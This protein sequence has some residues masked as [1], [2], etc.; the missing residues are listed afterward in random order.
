MYI[1]PNTVVYFCHNVPLDNTYEHTIYWHDNK[2]NGLAL[3]ED[4]FTLDNPS[5]PNP[6]LKF[7]LIAQ[8]FQDPNDNTIRVEKPWADLLD[9]N[10][11]CFRNDSFKN[12]DNEAKM[13]YAF[14]TKVTYINNNVTEIEYEIDVM[15]TW[16]YDYDLKEC[17]VER[18]HTLTDGWFEHTLAEDLD[19][20]DELVCTYHKVVDLNSRKT[21]N[22]QQISK[23][24][25]LLNRKKAGTQQPASGSFISGV[26]AGTDFI[27]G[28][29]AN[30]T[31]TIDGYLNQYQEDEIVAIYQYPNC[32]NDGVYYSDYVTIPKVG[33]E[34]GINEATSEY[35]A[36]EDYHGHNL[37]MACYPYSRL[38]L[39][40][41]AGQVAEFKYE[42]L[43]FNHE[44]YPNQALFFV[45]GVVL[46][47]PAII[48]YPDSYRGIYDRDNASYGGD[49]DSGMIMSN[50]PQCSWA[51]DT[52]K[53]WWAQNHNQFQTGLLTGA[54]TGAV[55][56]LTSAAGYG[57]PIPLATG[58]IS[59]GANIANQMALKMDMHY[60]PNMTHGTAQT[61]TL[62]TQ[63][64]RYRFDF[65]EMKVKPEVAMLIDQY[66]SKYGYKVNQVKVPNRK[67]R[68]F[69]T[70]T[71]TV[72]CTITETI[73][74]DIAKKICSIYDN[75]I[76][77]W[78]YGQTYKNVSHAPVVHLGEYS[79][80]QYTGSDWIDKWGFY[81]PPL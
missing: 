11:M 42:L 74:N 54:I 36:Y 4:Y 64:H 79:Y 24:C 51:G 22:G 17:F 20:G 50:F 15:Q 37:K 58:A 60:R 26:Y 3:Q 55:N 43:S 14:I 77:F 18:E 2:S 47:E 44:N 49:F 29:D 25:I 78:N 53:T 31:S 30:D 45:H 40:D 7:K 33:V 39:S 16:M 19:I 8:S 72:G 71:K 69:W 12:A 34:F 38:V 61:N 27:H 10:Y 48:I 68:K 70:Y 46:T 57:N 41:N 67:A 32:F 23:V 6:R 65:Y 56:S 62:R 80:F 59:V 66:F 73:G 28:L 13:F 35:S 75:G 81:D 9:C 21:V 5:N 76:T 52:F 63:M 1:T